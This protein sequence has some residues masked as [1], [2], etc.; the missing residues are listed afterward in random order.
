MD[1]RM[2]NELQV[3][4]LGAFSTQFK[5]SWLALTD[6]WSSIRGSLCLDKR[7]KDTYEHIGSFWGRLYQNPIVEADVS[8]CS[9]R[10]DSVFAEK[11]W[12]M[13]SNR[14]HNL[15]MTYTEHGT[16]L[17]QSYQPNGIA[18]AWSNFAAISWLILSF[19]HTAF[20]LA[21]F[22][23][24]SLRSPQHTP[25]LLSDSGYT[26]IQDHQPYSRFCIQPTLMVLTE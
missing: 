4:V 5:I 22:G 14:A 19:A 16:R 7:Q 12:S 23:A 18:L 2:V 25:C 10:A 21:T 1:L 11:K 15:L 6:T 20:M 24:P 17:C 26:R 13:W 9:F 8:P 3:L